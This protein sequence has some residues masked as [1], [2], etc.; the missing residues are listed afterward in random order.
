MDKTKCTGLQKALLR[1]G[2][3][4][5]L[6]KAIRVTEKTIHDWLRL[7]G[8][9]APPETWAE[10]TGIR[11]AVQNAG[12]PTAMARELGVTSQSVGIWIRQGF[13]P[14]KYVQQIELQ[15]G[16]PR[17]ELVSAKVRTRLGLGG[18]DL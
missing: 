18:G 15:F 14:L 3:V 4:P 11:R 13:A 17:V 7:E 5:A 2:S 16:V 10:N 6:A 12:G 8:V 9:E 1:V